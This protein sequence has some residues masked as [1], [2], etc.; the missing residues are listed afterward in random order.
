MSIPVVL[1][2][3]ELQKVWEILYQAGEN[4]E[5]EYQTY[6]IVRNP[7][8]VCEA[9]RIDAA[10]LDRIRAETGLIVFPPKTHNFCF[11]FLDTGEV[12]LFLDTPN[13]REEV[14][15]R[16]RLGSVPSFSEERR[17]PSTGRTTPIVE[18][19]HEDGQL[20]A[21]VIVG[22]TVSNII[23]EFARKIG[24][25]ENVPVLLMGETG[26]GKDLAATLIHQESSRS[27]KP[28][29]H[30]N[31][32]S[33]PRELVESELF[34]HERGAFTGAVRLHIGAFERASSG[35]IFLDE[36]GEMHPS[37]Q[38]KLLQVLQD[39]RFYRVGGDKEL[40]TSARLITATNVDLA[41]AMAS[42]RFREDLFYRIDVVSLTIPP[43]RERKEDIPAL[44]AHYLEIAAIQLEKSTPGVSQ[45]ALRFLIEYPWMGNVRQL[46]HAMLKTVILD[47]DGVIG[48]DDIAPVLVDKPTEKVQGSPLPI[49]TT[50][51]ETTYVG[52]S[53]RLRDISRRAVAEAE[54]AEIKRALDRCHWN[55]V[56]A[57]RLLKISYR[58]LLYK[59]KNYE[60]KSL[61]P[62]ALES[63]TK[64]VLPETPDTDA[65][66]EA[67][68]STPVDDVLTEDIATPIPVLP[69]VSATDV[70]GEPDQ[71]YFLDDEPAGD[72][73]ISIPGE[74][75]AH[76]TTTYKPASGTNVVGIEGERQY[77]REILVQSDW[78]RKT[79][80][81]ALG[82]S[83][84]SVG[85]RIRKLDLGDEEKSHLR[86]ILS[87]CRKMASVARLK[88]MTDQGV[89]DLCKRYGL[90]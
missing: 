46:K 89:V 50:S 53:A 76:D 35:T 25:L 70:S 72:V 59:I 42:G 30:I 82:I 48:L 90:R 47:E 21:P 38:A 73:D 56:K 64:S 68:S 11:L 61:E 88:G 58:A 34:G 1:S 9:R 13:R 45:E 67:Y 51:K 23:R 44:V 69:E 74:G 49:V 5:V 66:E 39:G 6:R 87:K 8:V 86:E 71:P 80:G 65:V 43:L 28:L 78:N 37:L 10:L 81:N 29:I 60:M 36:I 52:E 3:P 22:E 19:R 40:E 54:T 79:A 17:A 16:I 83:A 33:L 4:V 57:A 27:K 31:C 55:R 12:N 7:R 24:R 32:A 18:R 84:L 62:D 2:D 14:S 77:I 26:V 85:H 20:V 75:V 63:L 15:Y 41:K